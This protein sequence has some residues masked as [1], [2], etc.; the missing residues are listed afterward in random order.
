MGGEHNLHNLDD[1]RVRHLLTADSIASEQREYE[2]CLCEL[3]KYDHR[4][5]IVAYLNY[6][7]RSSLE[8]SSFCLGKRFQLHHVCD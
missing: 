5:V 1:L 6:R 7:P 3:P 4:D 2:L 8:A